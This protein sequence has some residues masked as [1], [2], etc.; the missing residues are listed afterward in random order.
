MSNL[1]TIL[2]HIFCFHKIK[3]VIGKQKTTVKGEIMAFFDL[4]MKKSWSSI[5]LYYLKQRH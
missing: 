5:I 1:L 4:F 2:K 3:N